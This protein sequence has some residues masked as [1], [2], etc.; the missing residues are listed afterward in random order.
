MMVGTRIQ[1]LCQVL[2]SM[3]M[4]S[5]KKNKE[6]KKETSGNVQEMDANKQLL[7][8]VT[9]PAGAGKSTAIEVAQ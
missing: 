4:N 6:R 7:M 8:F 9:G 5:M 1:M 3:I 2:Q